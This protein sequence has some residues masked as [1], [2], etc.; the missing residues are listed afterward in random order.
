METKEYSKIIQNIDKNKLN[1]ILKNM[2]EK[3]FKVN[4]FVK[5][6]KAPVQKISLALKN[7]KIK[8]ID[9]F[10]EICSIY[11]VEN[12]IKGIGKESFEIEDIKSI[13]TDENKVGLISYLL[14]SKPELEIEILELLD[15]KDQYIKSEG[16]NED[17]DNSIK[18][19]ILS[20]IVDTGRYLCKIECNK[21]EE[22]YFLKPLFLIENNVLRKIS[23]ENIF[24]ST[25][26][27]KISSPINLKTENIK[28][29]K[30]TI[31]TIN[32]NDID[33]QPK[34]EYGDIKSQIY[35]NKIEPR[36]NTDE[37]NI[38]EILRLDED[39]DINEFKCRKE[40]VIQNIYLPISRKV[41]IENKESLYGP[42]EWKNKNGDIE[43]CLVGGSHFINIFNIQELKHTIYC[44]S[45][46]LS[47]EAERKLIYNKN[48]NIRKPEF[49]FI[50]D[51]SL[52]DKVSKL[53][54]NS[55]SDKNSI[56][57]KIRNL[58]EVDF[59]EERKERALSIFKS[60]DLMD[61][62]I[63]DII[64]NILNDDT[65]LNYVIGKILENPNYFNKIREKD[66]QIT[67]K[68][69]ELKKINNQIQQKEEELKNV[70]NYIEEVKESEIE[71]RIKEKNNKIEKLEKDIEKK[72]YE[73][74]EIKKRIVELTEDYNVAFSRKEWDKKIK[75]VEQRDSFF[76]KET[77]LFEN[78]IDN[79]LATMNTQ[80]V[81]F[82]F[83][84]MI[85]NKMM[86]AANDYEKDND[87]K[88]DNDTIVAIEKSNFDNVL[89]LNSKEE[90][91]SYVEELIVKTSNRT[92]FSRN[93]IINIL[94][95]ISQG[96]LTV[97][98]GAPGTGK[99]SLCT[100]IAKALGLYRNDV[101]NRYVEVSVE[102]G[103]TSKR[104]FIG[105]YNP[106][107]KTFDKNDKEL[108]N[109][110]ARMDEENKK[111]N[112]YFPFLIL[113]DEANLSSMEHYWA[114]FMNVCDLDKTN[115]KIN[116]CEDYN[117]DISDTLR[118]LATI[119]YDHTTE[120]LSPRLID[121]AWIILL[122]SSSNNIDDIDVDD[123]E[124]K[125][126]LPM[127]SFKDF[128]N[129]FGANKKL[130]KETKGDSLEPEI[131]DKLSEIYELYSEEGISI[132]PRI[133]KM[134]KKYCIVG[135]NLFDDS[136]NIYVALDYA[137]AQKILPLINGYG[138]SYKKFLIK[139]QE[140]C[141][142]GSMPKCN[143]IIKNIIRNGDKSMQYY[144][145]FAR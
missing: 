35:E 3:G 141:G 114:E 136:D 54:S 107:T 2:G 145:F 80:I 76:R 129:I 121:R 6:E 102:K 143:D 78:Q 123:Y 15:L 56:R 22:F 71:K 7:E 112:N 12:Y 37:E 111:G 30:F 132:S 85:A 94:L 5:L 36:S 33:F 98:A 131:S 91:I 97:F 43:I 106:L 113:L 92:N 84:K 25:G 103:W 44:I 50:D 9:F 119:N 115:R 120:I 75:E 139:L 31:A 87:Y 89:K 20:E 72:E 117:F 135:K 17:I 19:L 70:N 28:N 122:N 27:I 39:I 61:D 125:G 57:N 11:K 53:I 55:R 109:A 68:E 63:D 1:K 41:Y 59:S 62:T 79:K 26:K 128:Q 66:E 48:L 83:N 49:D 116:L 82:A 24:G 95:C 69:E 108:F 10:K 100:I 140:K 58:G 137:I 138:D 90:V 144:Q 65:Q 105:Y 60:S 13:M 96:F 38:Y 118:F 142:K 81:D 45:P 74:D 104:D 52:K 4:G 73:R 42:F 124:I 88:K 110:F 8:S 51:S 130:N 77:V 133:V 67:K 16:N 14:L 18:D 21:S 40:R 127:I 64:K 99:T 47:Y 93:D 101:H 23:D 46:E 126:D 32:K 29:Y 134:I 86:K 34:D